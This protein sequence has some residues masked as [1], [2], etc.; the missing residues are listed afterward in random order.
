MSKDCVNISVIIP[1]YNVQDYITDCLDSLINQSCLPKEIICIDD[2]ST[3]N[4]LILI[5]KYAITWDRIKIIQQSNQGVSKARNNGIE[6][7][8][9]DYILFV[10]SDD[11]INTNLFYD[12]KRLLNTENN[13]D[14]FYFDYSAFKDDEKPKNLNPI[15]TLDIK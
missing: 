9:G 4:T 13:L 2:G 5:Q 11:I 12:F 14:F 8:K 15:Q 1:C 10:D 6:A 3:D 7:A